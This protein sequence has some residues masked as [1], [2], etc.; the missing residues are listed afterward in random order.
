MQSL[1]KYGIVTDSQ[2]VILIESEYLDISEGAAIF[3]NFVETIY[4]GDMKQ[5]IAVYPINKIQSITKQNDY[6]E[7]EILAQRACEK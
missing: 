4:G 6:S 3:S 1:T 2:D 7:E 5:I